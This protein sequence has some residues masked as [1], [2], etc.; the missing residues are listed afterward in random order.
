MAGDWR[1]VTLGE[2][3]DVKHGYA[4]KG[5]FF[6]EAPTDNVLLTPG[7]FAIG[8]GFKGDKHK[9]YDGPFPP[10]YILRPGDII[11]TM[12]DLSKGMDTLGYPAKVPACPGRRFLHNQRLG[13]LIPKSKDVHLNYMYYV[14]CDAPYRHSIVSAATGST[15]RHT[16]PTRIQSYEFS[17]PPIEEQRAIANVLGS[18]DD[19]IELNH[20]TSAT[21]DAMARG[22]FKS[23]FIDFDPVRAKA[24]GRIPAG[25]DADTAQLFPS[26][27]DDSELG[28][29]PKGWQRRTLADV[30]SYMS[31]GI[32]PSYAD[33]GVMVINQKC[34]RGGE[35]DFAKARR[36]DAEKRGVSSRLLKPYDILVNS[37]GVGT[38][39]RVAQLWRMPETDIITDSHVTV[40]R[41]GAAIAPSWL[42]L[43]LRS[44]MPEI[45]GM[46]QGSTGQ[47]ELPRSALAAMTVIVPPSLVQRV[48]DSVVSPLLDKISLN[49][50]TVGTLTQLRDTLLPRLLSGALPIRDAEQFLP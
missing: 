21:L 23:W 40:V 24:E 8:G 11:V 45:E 15:V 4:F 27:F 5:E 7:N 2:L 22:L 12:T 47:T 31:R 6:S 48:F 20:Q 38:L 16:S 39:G 49:K 14:M 50:E 33:H 18:L 41:A 43:F 29:I 32:G 13:K 17:L 34:I 28:P 46:A 25:M 1:T 19:K 26:E 30:S 37:T 42:G 9:Y 35:I 10:E 44:S 3:V 36:H